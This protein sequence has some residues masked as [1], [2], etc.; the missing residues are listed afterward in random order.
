M[1]IT[2]E[3]ELCRYVAK[4][5]KANVIVVENQKQLDKILQVTV[6]RMKIA[7]IITCVLQIRERLP[8]LKA[9]VQ[10]RGKLSQPYRQVYDVQMHVED[11]NPGC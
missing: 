9:I 3:P 7:S 11:A 2:C 10:Y 4:H 8:E 5:S 1:Y 6:M